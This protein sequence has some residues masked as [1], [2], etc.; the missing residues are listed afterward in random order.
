MAALGRNLA[1]L[2]YSGQATEE[3]LRESPL[4]PDLRDILSP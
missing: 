2:I 4:Y 3:Q 1:G